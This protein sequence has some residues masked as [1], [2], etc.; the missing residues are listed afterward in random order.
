[1]VEQ[2]LGVAGVPEAAA[3]GEE[4]GVGVVGESTEDI[5]IVGEVV[6]E[7]DVIV[8]VAE[9]AVGEVAL[10]AIIT[11]VVMQRIDAVSGAGRS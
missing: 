4:V 6:G 7:V 8:G 3:V 11:L 1:M 9:V 5:D 10:V 2:A